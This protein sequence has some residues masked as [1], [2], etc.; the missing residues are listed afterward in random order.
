V[1]RSANGG[2]T[3]TTLASSV[4]TPSYQD[5]TVAAG[6]SYEYEVVATDS[7]GSSSP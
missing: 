5:T 6:T 3:W 7:G 1:L 2:T 4:S